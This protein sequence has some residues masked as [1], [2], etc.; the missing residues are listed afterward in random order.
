MNLARRLELNM[1]FDAVLMYRTYWVYQRGKMGV[2]CAD[3]SKGA[4]SYDV[5][6]PYSIRYNR[7]GWIP[8]FITLSI[9]TQWFTQISH[10]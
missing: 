1:R 5:F 10:E 8:Y 9:W 2:P 7:I 4:V 6:W 3:S